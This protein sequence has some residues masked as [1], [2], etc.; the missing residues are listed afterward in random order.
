MGLFRL[1]KTNTHI[2]NEKGEKALEQSINM[3][4]FNLKQENKRQQ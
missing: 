4:G 2:N 3:V 1:K